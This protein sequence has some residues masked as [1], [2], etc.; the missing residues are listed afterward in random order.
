M[1]RPLL[2]LIASV[3][4]AVLIGLGVSAQ[5]SG[6]SGAQEGP[7]PPGPHV[8]LVYA[9][10]QTCPSTTLVGAKSSLRAQ[11]TTT[12]ANITIAQA[13]ITSRGS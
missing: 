2:L 11:M 5:D 13:Q 3:A 6:R 4:I 7:L 8:D 1:T 10:C 12:P 9:K